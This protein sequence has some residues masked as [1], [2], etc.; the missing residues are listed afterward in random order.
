MGAKHAGIETDAANPVADQ[1]CILPGRQAPAWPARRSEQKIVG[2]S[3]RG[4]DVIIDRL[5]GLFGHLEPHRHAG[6]FL[7][8][9]GTLD[10]VTVRRNVL[11]LEGD[12]IA[13]AQLA[14]D[15][16]IEHRQVALAVRDLE[17]GADRPDVLWP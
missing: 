11:Y 9:R 6:L 2:L 7:A 15:R 8:H 3:V 12:D 17:L 4:A 5:P 10:G 1:A 13:P 14:V 16:Q